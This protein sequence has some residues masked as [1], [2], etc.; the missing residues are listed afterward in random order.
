[1]VAAALLDF[2]L[3]A[4]NPWKISKSSNFEYIIPISVKILAQEEKYVKEN[5][6]IYIN[7]REQNIPTSFPVIPNAQI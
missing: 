2:K 1:M 7:L 6:C 3:F 5:K 4:R